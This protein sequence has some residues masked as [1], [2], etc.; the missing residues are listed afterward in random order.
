M[1]SIVTE[2][3]ILHYEALGRGRPVILLHGWINSWDVWRDCMIALA[4]SRQY[5][6]YA[7]DFWGF[8]DSAK[9]NG[10][11]TPSF[12]IDG[13]VEMVRQFMDSLGILISPLMGHS[14]G[15]TVALQFALK[16]PE[17]TQKVAVVG[18]P[19][20]G[21]T[22]NPFLKI[23]GMD[24]LAGLVWRYPGVFGPVAHQATKM[25]MHII[26]AKDS[27]QIR[28]MIFRDWERTTYESFFRSIADLRRTDLRAELKNLDK[29]AHGIYGVHDNIVSPTNAGLFNHTL[30]A[31]NVTMMAHS[32]HFP[33]TDEP[34]RFLTTLESFLCQQPATNGAG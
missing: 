19:I 11:T 7:L 4:G 26:L 13:Y 29:P 31:A 33:M 30:P 1:S 34:G 3:G 10:S 25:I 17:R 12:R 18:S 14:M 20:V 9:G 24:S 22:L 5:R 21:S 27:A 28:K 15:G 23:A 2:Q 32:R 16:Y 8:G 6:V